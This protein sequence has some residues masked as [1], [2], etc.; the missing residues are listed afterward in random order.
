MAYRVDIVLDQGTDSEA[1]YEFF[2][3]SNRPISF[4][5]YTAQMQVRRTATSQTVIDDLST[6]GTPDRIGFCG[7]LVTIKW[8]RS[9]TQEIKSGRYVYDLEVTS[10]N[11]AVTRLMEGAFVIKQEVTR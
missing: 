9:V 2:D 3:N 8:P 1:S 10:P 6:E 11:G 7:N 4:S 5:G